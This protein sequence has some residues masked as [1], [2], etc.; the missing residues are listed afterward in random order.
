MGISFFSTLIASVLLKAIWAEE[1]EEEEQE[2]E[3]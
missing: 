1:D 2:E 3:K